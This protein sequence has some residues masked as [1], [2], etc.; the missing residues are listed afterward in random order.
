MT[1]DKLKDCPFCNAE[2]SFCDCDEMRKVCWIIECKNCGSFEHNRNSRK[3]SLRVWNTRVAVK[4]VSVEEIEKTV[5]DK[6][7][8][9]PIAGDFDRTRAMYAN[10]AAIKTIATAIHKL[11]YGGEDG[12]D[13]PKDQE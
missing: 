3:K 2:V 4:K 12:K 8:N 5:K 13:S 6:I 10:E 1:E 11:V 9:I 7:F